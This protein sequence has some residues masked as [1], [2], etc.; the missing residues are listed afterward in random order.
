VRQSLEPKFSEI[1]D[2]LSTLVL[3]VLEGFL[4]QGVVEVDLVAGD[5]IGDY[6]E[7]L[8]KFKCTEPR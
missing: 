1:L 3:E 6:I 4:S 7:L 5:L 2:Y 8:C